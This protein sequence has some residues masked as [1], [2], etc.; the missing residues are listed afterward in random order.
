ML[1][2]GNMRREQTPLARRR[3]QADAPRNSGEELC[4]TRQLCDDAD[5][6]RPDNMRAQLLTV[7]YSSGPS[8]H[9]G[10]DTKRIF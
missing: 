4:V 5:T 2:R 8:A 3:A 1:I 7:P 9:R 6:V 10:W